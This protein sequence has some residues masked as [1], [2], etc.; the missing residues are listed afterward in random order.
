MADVMRILSRDAFAEVLT[1]ARRRTRTLDP[2][3]WPLLR[4]I[5]AQLQFIAEQTKRGRV[6]HEDDRLRTTL[7]PLAARNLEDIDPEYADQLEELDYTFRRYPQL[8]AGPP[9]RRRGVLQVWSGRETYRKLVLDLGVPRTVG[10]AHADFVVHGSPDGSPHF[11]IVWDGVSAHVQAEGSHRLAVNGEST[12][13]GEMANRGWMTAVRTT[14]RFLVEDRT[15]PPEPVAPSAAALAALTELERRCHTGHL[16]AIIDAARSDR[17]LQLVEES[18]DPYASLYDG[19]QGR[20]FDDIAPYLV[21]LQPGSWLL[22]R[23]VTE[24]WGDAWGIYVQ[25]GAGFDKVRRHLRQFLKVEVEGEAKP[26]FFRFYDPRVLR[27]FAAVMAPE[28]RSELLKAVDGVLFERSGPDLR[29]GVI[30]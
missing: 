7:G 14:Y 23:L 13:Y 8:P 3:R 16:Y 22:E 24:G 30:E 17:A 9:V 4:Q 2:S 19:E 6:P 26:M 27:T 1:E 28:Q 21:H 11:Q 29:M 25:S 5:E 12:W 15:P 18:I 10:N 20:A